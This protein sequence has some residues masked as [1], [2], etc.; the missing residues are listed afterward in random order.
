[1]YDVTKNNYLMAAINNLNRLICY[2]KWRKHQTCHVA[3]CFNYLIELKQKML[4]LLEFATTNVVFFFDN[5]T[6]FLTADPFKLD[7]ILHTENKISDVI[8]LCNHDN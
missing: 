6:E 5:T 2:K 7:V 3:S 8:C 1:M 4:I